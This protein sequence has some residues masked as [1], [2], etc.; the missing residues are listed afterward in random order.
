VLVY[1]FLK[2]ESREERRDVVEMAQ[3]RHAAY[4]L[5]IKQA[6]CGPPQEAVCLL[7]SQYFYVYVPIGRSG[8]ESI[9]PGRTLDTEHCLLNSKE[10]M[11]S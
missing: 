7:Y 6:R 9:A 8:M 11:G 3:P 2:I 5:G 10:W 1:I 4:I